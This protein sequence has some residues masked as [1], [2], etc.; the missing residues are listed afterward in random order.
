M[1]KREAFHILHVVWFLKPDHLHASELDAQ[2]E[3]KSKLRFL[4]FL[5]SF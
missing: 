4:S 5:G 3:I 2:Q 1:F